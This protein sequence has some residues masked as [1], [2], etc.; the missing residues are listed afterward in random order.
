MKIKGIKYRIVEILLLLFT[1]VYISPLLLTIN[2]SFKQPQ[3]F[4]KPF[5]AL[6][7]K[8]SLQNYIQTYEL[9]HMGIALINSIIIT[10]I[11]IA[12][13]VF[14]ASMAAYGIARCESRYNKLLYTLFVSGLVLPFPVIMV[15]VMKMV[16]FFGL[17]DKTGLIILYLAL[18]MSF[19][20]FLFVGFIR[21]SVPVEL[22]E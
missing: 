1:F 2:N 12:G 11:S 22:E 17:R 19:A 18:G 4:A 14:L 3:E 7:E 15:P 9:T 10:V 8:L 20:I 13:I 6:P 5:F 16:G 21:S